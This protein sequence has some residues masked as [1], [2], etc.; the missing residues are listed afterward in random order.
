M[1]LNR[2][3]IEKGGF[4]VD[5][6]EASRR[7]TT[8][9]ATIGEFISEGA[10]LEGDKFRLEKRGIVWVVSHETFQFGPN[11]TGLATLKTTLTHKGILALN[12][13]VIDPGWEGPLAT[14]LVNFS[15][16]TVEIARGEPFFR[17]M[18]MKH[19]KTGAATVRKEKHSYTDDIL[20]RSR[21][22]SA[23]FLN[24]HSLVDEVAAA[25][26]KLPRLAVAIGWAGLGVALASI[27]L[28]IAV[29]VWSDHQKE[30]ATTM[31]LEKRVEALEAK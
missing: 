8:Y 9:D 27:L 15:G 2:V 3:Q 7:S 4:V 20:D 19:L 5:A 6:V 10:C 17:V 1:I 29:S 23:T 30:A 22:F 11:Y 28:P 12:V 26:F 24:T 18:F 14:A 13:G 25:V 21:Y 16:S 31:A